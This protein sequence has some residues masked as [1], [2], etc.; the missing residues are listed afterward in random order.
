MR[1]Q[2]SASVAAGNGSNPKSPPP[3]SSLLRQYIVLALSV[4]EAIDDF[5]D[6]PT[7]DHMAF[8]I[9]QRCNKLLWLYRQMNDVEQ[10]IVE[11]SHL[12]P[13]TA[14]AIQFRINHV[15][16]TANNDLM[17]NLAADLSH[18]LYT[19]QAIKT[20]CLLH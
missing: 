8:V 18:I 13:K 20:S 11:G 3:I 4:Q 2:Y 14:S 5:Q 6:V 7:S 9:R 10:E 19:T 16:T 15:M 12:P 17:P 1:I